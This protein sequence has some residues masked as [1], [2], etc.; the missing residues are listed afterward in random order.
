MLVTN[1]LL[2]ALYDYLPFS[3]VSLNSTVSEEGLASI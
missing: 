1:F 3:A 2:I